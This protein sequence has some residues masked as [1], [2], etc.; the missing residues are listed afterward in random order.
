MTYARFLRKGIRE[1]GDLLSSWFLDSFFCFW[2]RLFCWF[3]RTGLSSLVF[4]QE[5][6]FSL[7]RSFTHTWHV[8]GHQ[9]MKD[10]RGW[11]IQRN[12]ERERILPWFYSC[13]S[14]ASVIPS[15]TCLSSKQFGSL[16]ERKLSSSETDRDRKRPQVKDR[17]N[18]R[19]KRE[20]VAV[21]SFLLALYLGHPLLLILLNSYCTSFRPTLSLSRSSLESE[22]YFSS[23][24]LPVLS[25]ESTLD[26]IL[27]FFE[28]RKDITV[29][30]EAEGS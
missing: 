2:S 24:F 29:I 1:E 16:K 22:S 20:K 18:E 13:P 27:E 15:P 8:F 23:V 26:S 30:Q 3:W 6:L 4:S 5:V 17:E 14:F 28:E 11:E 21:I 10:V 9:W 12:S 7:S 19:K 25:G